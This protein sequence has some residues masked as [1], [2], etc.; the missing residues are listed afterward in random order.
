MR[1]IIALAMILFGTGLISGLMR[2]LLKKED[3]DYTRW[4]KEQD[5]LRH[6]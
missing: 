6:E 1:L 5:V 3:P 4:K 2:S